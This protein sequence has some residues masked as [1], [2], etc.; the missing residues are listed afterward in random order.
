MA[1]PLANSLVVLRRHL[2][3]GVG[4]VCDLD[5]TMG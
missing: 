4:V 1:W 5:V 2:P 3:N